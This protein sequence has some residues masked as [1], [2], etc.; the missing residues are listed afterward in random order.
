MRSLRRRVLEH[1]VARWAAEFLDALARQR[2]TADAGAPAASDAEAAGS[3][4]LGGAL[5]H[6]L[7]RRPVLV[8]LDF[9][10]VLAPIVQTPGDARALPRSLAALRRLV[11]AEGVQVALVSGRSLGDLRT[12]AEPPP[13][14]VLVASHG[15]EVE[16][17]ASPEVP[18]EVLALVTAA[19]QGV[20]D[21]HPGT[22]LEHKPTATVLHT[23]GTAPDVAAS[24]SAAAL[25]AVSGIEGAHVIQGK[26]V[27]EVTAVRAD[28][29]TALRGLRERLGA[30]AVLYAGDDVTDEDA[31]RTLDAAAGDVGVKVG[32]GETSAAHRVDDPE[33]VAD[34][35]ES[36]ADLLSR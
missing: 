34:L 13:G 4:A 21:A 8:A 15:A 5:Q 20:V 26:Q 12:V 14:V 7:A 17:A 18:A 29:G 33:G 32:A 19:L 1:D 36:L 6:L 30:G 10:G 24:A 11:G 3:A 31:L 23:R 2:S 35:L 28:K 9:D 25:A 27:V 22:S 16:G